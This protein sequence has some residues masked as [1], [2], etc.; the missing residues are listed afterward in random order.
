MFC[1]I[2]KIAE[3]PIHCD[4]K[5]LKRCMSVLLGPPPS[6]RVMQNAFPNELETQSVNKIEM[7]VANGGCYGRISRTGMCTDQSAKTKLQGQMHLY[8][9]E[10]CIQAFT[11]ALQNKQSLENMHT[12][13]THV[14]T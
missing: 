10:K 4:K 7:I 8:I 5:S 1:G 9:I 2:R 12:E 3:S 14:N 6:F 11:T 13:C